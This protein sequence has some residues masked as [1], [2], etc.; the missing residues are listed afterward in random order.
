MRTIS[1][2]W[3]RITKR[4]VI[5]IDIKGDIMFNVIIKIMNKYCYYFMQ[6]IIMIV[7]CLFW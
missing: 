3:K 4:F 5:F 1:T 2:M 7:I 6:L